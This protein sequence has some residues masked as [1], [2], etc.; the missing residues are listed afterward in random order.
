M[1]CLVPLKSSVGEDSELEGILVSSRLHFRS[2]P[3]QTD[4][5]GS[6]LVEM[7]TLSHSFVRRM[8]ASAKTDLLAAVTTSID[9]L[10][11]GYI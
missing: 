2:Y 10:Q 5:Q 7:V 4:D 11:A 3:T 6:R 1:V 8:L 9:C